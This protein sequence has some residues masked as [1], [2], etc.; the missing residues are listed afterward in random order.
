MFT[1]LL[2]YETLSNIAIFLSNLWC[3]FLG[4]DSEDDE[5]GIT[6]GTHMLA[7]VAT[8]WNKDSQI[9]H[10]VARYCTKS[11]TKEY[12]VNKITDITCALAEYGFVVNCLGCDGASENRG[13]IKMLMDDL[14]LSIE[15]LLPS[16]L[17][18]L[19]RNATDL[20]KLPKKMKV[21]YPHPSVDEQ[22]I[23]IGGDMPHAVKKVVN[24]MENS[25][26]RDHARDLIFEGEHISMQVLY[27]VYQMTPDFKHENSMRKYKNLSPEVFEK[28]AYSRMNVQKAFALLSNTMIKLISDWGDA[29]NQ[30]REKDGAPKVRFEAY[31]KFIRMFDDY[32]DWINGEETWG[33]VERGTVK[34]KRIVNGT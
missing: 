5:S 4:A 33:C 23:F 1:L 12:M 2:V 9:Q 22:F 30:V 16:V 24:A 21:A 27:E 26:K 32:K 31:V 7:F 20:N 28:T 11:M 34:T 25:G 14:G 3:F 6:A 17:T 15:D 10:C 29:Y 19:E 18:H 8:V 13:A